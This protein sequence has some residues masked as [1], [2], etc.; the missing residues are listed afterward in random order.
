[1]AGGRVALVVG[2]AFADNKSLKP[3][4]AKITATHVRALM[5]VAEHRSI[6][7]A[8]LN[9]GISASALTRAAR[10]LEAAIERTLIHPGLQGFIP[11]KPLTE[12]SRRF[13]LA[14]RELT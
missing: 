8:A 5:A 2:P 14:C 4:L 7:T 11:S 10:D 3:L 1:M 13:G 12:L 6:E 9:L